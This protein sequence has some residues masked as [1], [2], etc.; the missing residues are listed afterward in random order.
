MNDDGTVSWLVIGIICFVG[1]TIICCIAGFFRWMFRI[2]T[3]IK[4]LGEIKSNT[5]PK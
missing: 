2:N 3:I 5:E 4:L 1:F